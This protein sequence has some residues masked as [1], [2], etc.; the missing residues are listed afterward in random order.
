MGSSDSVFAK[1]YVYISSLFLT[2]Q[3]DIGFYKDNGILI[4]R[5]CNGRTI[6]KNKESGI[7]ISNI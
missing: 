6:E 1:S 2:L 4:V 3:K 7:E 5:N